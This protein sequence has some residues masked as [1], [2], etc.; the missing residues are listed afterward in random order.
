M[1]S[2]TPTPYPSNPT[3]SSDNLTIPRVD[4]A[5]STLQSTSPDARSPTA[6]A[7]DLNAALAEQQ[8]QKKKVDEPLR[9]GLPQSDDVTFPINN[10]FEDELARNVTLDANGN[11][12]KLSQTKKWALLALL[13]LAFF[14][15]IWAYS[16][17][18]TDQN[19]MISY[20][21]TFVSAFFIFTDQISTDLNILFEQQSWVIVSYRLTLQN[22]LARYMLTREQQTSY[23]V[24]FASFLLFW[25]RVSDLY[26]P[27]PV[28]SYGF[29]ALGII[30][31]VISF[32]PEKFSF[33]VLRAIS[34][35]AGATLIPAAFRL[36]VV[37]FEPE[38]L[39]KAF[40]IYG[41]SGA[42]ANVTGIIIAGFISYIPGGGQMQDWRW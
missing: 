42:L 24:T 31:L 1:S 14:I 20:T 7:V 26:S 13:S 35:I 11:P 32:L 15:D 37:I 16:Y 5:A 4:T 12:I 2:T 41:L 40:T 27:K 39:N 18:L 8:Q 6:T 29:V 19:V 34:G 3:S 10:G 21:D 30:N 9:S 23:A 33:F 25:G 28:F 22:L 38:E 36:I 17:V